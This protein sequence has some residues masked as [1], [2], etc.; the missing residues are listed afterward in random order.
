MNHLEELR[1]DAIESSVYLSVG[2]DIP[3]SQDDVEPRG[4][5]PTQDNPDVVLV[6]DTPHPSVDVQLQYPWTLQASAIYRN[7]NL[8]QIQSMHL[9]FVHEPTV[10]LT[11]DPS[12]RLSV[13]SAVTLINLHWM[14]PWNG[15][16]ELGLSGLVQTQILP[17]LTEEYGGQV[18]LEQH[19][20]PWFSITLSA[21]GAYAPPVQGQSGKFAVDAGVGALFHFDGF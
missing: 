17:K 13:Q 1:M 12:G 19:V 5:Y 2:D 8:A 11:I 4:D 7:L 16:L 18:Q 6:S 20:V 9:D 14:P 3:V 21:T 15:E 10:S